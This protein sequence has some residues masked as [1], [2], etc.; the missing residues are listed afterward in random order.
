MLGEC[1]PFLFLRHNV[2]KQRKEP[3]QLDLFV[4]REEGY[5]FKAI[6][7][8]KKG[9]AK[10]ILQ[11]HNGRGSQ[12]NLFADQKT[13]CNMDYVPTR[14]LSGNRLFYQSAVFAH[15]LYRELQMIDRTTDRV[16][17]PKRSSLW[18]F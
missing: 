13:Q 11:F 12:E 8:D 16:T 18:I 7:T 15:N 3:V 6:A 1:L 10:T 2:K 17:A 4:P 5:E 9:A 14:K